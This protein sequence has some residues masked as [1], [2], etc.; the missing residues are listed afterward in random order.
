MKKWIGITGW[1]F[2][3][4]TAAFFFQGGIQKLT[5]S[6][7]MIEMFNDLGYSDWFR[8]AVGLLEVAGAILLA[9]PRSTHYAAAA[10]SVL[11]IG[12]TISELTSGHA[13]E[14]ALAGQWIVILVLIV[15]FRVRSI[16]NK[17]I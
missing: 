2:V 8:L 16:R 4:A 11:M 12:A 14:A 6:N 15:F 17:Q 3:W 13:F 1:I 7:Q 10:L 9:V 5:G